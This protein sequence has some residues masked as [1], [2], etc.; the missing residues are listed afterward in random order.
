MMKHTL[1]YIVCLAVF[2]F[3]WV[4]AQAQEPEWRVV[5][6]GEA[7][8]IPLY[9]GQ[10][11]PFPMLEQPE[12]KKALA[13][14]QA[15]AVEAMDERTKALED[16][17]RA[18]TEAVNASTALIPQMERTQITAYID[19]Q[20]G[21]MVL[22]DGKWN[23]VGQT[24]SVIQAINPDVLE[25]INNLNELDEAT[26]QALKAKLDNRLQQEPV[27]KVEIISIKKKEVTLRTKQRTFTRKISQDAW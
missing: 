7:E 19:G 14:E 8:V 18:A 3:A 4:M 21:P 25:K 13:E 23:G 16:A 26:A 22:I 2:P 6:E 24:F 15:P 1:F 5:N 9:Q 17:K 12:E 10:M 11:N 27:G 20:S